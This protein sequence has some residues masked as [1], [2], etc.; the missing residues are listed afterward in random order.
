MHVETVT[1]PYCWE[2][3]EVFLDLS[4][5]AQRQV[6]D[7]SVCCR[8]IVITYRAEGGELAALEIEAENR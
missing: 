4:V 7:C 8:P 5:E 3:I 1:C 2:A 6:E